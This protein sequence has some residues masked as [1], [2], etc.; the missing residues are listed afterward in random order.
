MSSDSIHQ[1]K[2]YLALS[3]LDAYSLNRF[4]K[5]LE[6]PYFNQNLK[7]TQYYELLEPALKNTNIDPPAKQ[8]IWQ[9]LTKSAYNDTKFRKLN[10]DLLK[11][12]QS[13]LAQ[14]V[15]ESNP[16][17]KANYL[18]QAVKQNNIISLYRSA[19]RTASR[20]SEQQYLKPS[21]FYYYQYE[22][23]RNFYEIIDFEVQRSEISNIE[24]IVE[25]LD[26]FY[27]SEKLRYYCTILSRKSHIAHDYHV[28]FVEHII[29]HVE[30]IEFESIV[31]INFYYHI[32]CILTKQESLPHYLRLKSLIKSHID[33]VPEL[34]RE[35]IV[36]SALNY[37]ARQINVGNQDFL[38]ELFRL[39]QDFL[40]KDLLMV[41]GILT[42]WKFR[43]VIVTG[44]RLA[45]YEWV[46]KFI[47]MYQQHLEPKYREN[48]VS[49]NKAN[50]FFYKKEYDQV[51]Q[52]LQEVEYED[53]SYNLNAKTMLILTYY[54]TEEQEAL[55]SLLETFRIYLHRNNKI[56]QSRKELYLPLV[57]FT[58]KLTRLKPNETKQIN[59]L[60]KQIEEHQAVVNKNWLLEKLDELEG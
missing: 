46:D 21:E 42:P 16:L 24:K 59:Q 34:E 41:N 3:Q 52:M 7:I 50:L 58:K 54:E 31:P 44:L 40:G 25:N 36:G 12:V 17:H 48:A 53:I 10:T 15:Y 8:E 55:N 43:N 30:S 51:I 27:I 20:L 13:F 37:C 1:S 38:R 4:K 29:E 47:E 5:Y 28:L 6:S 39:Y 9:S 19:M 11:L 60:R 33:E 32:Y 18:L 49:F 23:E 35:E 22:F 2:V 14:E 57:S 26:L 56:A 45:E